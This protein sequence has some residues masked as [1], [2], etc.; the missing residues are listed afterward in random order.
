MKNK[1]L[2]GVIL[3]I[4]AV[5]C[6]TDDDNNMRVD[7]QPE[8]TM[9]ETTISSLPGMDLSLKATINDPAGIKTVNIKYEPWD[10][11]KTIIKDSLPNSYNLDYTFKVPERATENSEHIISVTSTNIG[12]ISTTTD[13]TVTLDLDVEAPQISIEEPMD[14]ATVLLGDGDEIEFNITVTDNES[15]SEFRIE[16]N[17]FNDILEISG[18]SF[19][20]ENS[21]N[22][23]STGAYSFN[24][25]VTDMA[26]NS[27]STS[28]TVNVFDELKFEKMYMTEVTSDTQLTSDVFGVPAIM[29]G[30]STEEEQG[31]VFSGRYYAAEANTEIRF[32]PQKA[33][34]EPYTFGADPNEEGSLVNGTSSEVD[35][36]VL[37]SKGY[38]E[39]KIDLRDFTYSITP[40]TPTDETFDFVQ[41]I[42][43]GM[44]VNGENTCNADADDSF[45]CFHFSSGKALIQDEDNLYRFYATVEIFDEPD[46]E[47][48]N[49]MIMNSNKE[50]WAPFW[51]FDENKAVPQGGSTLT[52][53]EES[54]DG[55][56]QFIFDTHLNTVMITPTN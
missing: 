4:L 8:F 1:I 50:G 28:F 48:A 52:F 55:T 21:L 46:S 37:P 53:S 40:Y 47:G 45:R 44:R 13:F 2:L 3:L 12:G 6:D 16:S 35:P 7:S 36:L 10:L 30:S 22:I 51:R 19:T 49:G 32:I 54:L 15:L 11:D 24:A 39:L 20:Y 14:G 27:N 42:A 34:F 25:I 38:Y 43:T 17:D 26:G 33:S 9:A 18:S 23:E 29:N 31:F 56:Y 41:I 5:G